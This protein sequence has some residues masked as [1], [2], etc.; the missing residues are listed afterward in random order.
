MRNCRT[1]PVKDL[2]PVPAI[3]EQKNEDLFGGVRNDIAMPAKSAM[4][5][6][7]WALVPDLLVLQAIQGKSKWQN[8]LYNKVLIVGFM[9]KSLQML[10]FNMF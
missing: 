7:I 6:Q 10:K 4:S 1:P 5:S 3:T 8:C 9:K 2:P